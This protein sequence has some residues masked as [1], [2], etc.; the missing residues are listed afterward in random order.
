MIPLPDVSSLLLAVFGM[1]GLAVIAIGIAR[2]SRDARDPSARLLDL[3]IVGGGVGAVVWTAALLVARQA[4]PLV[5]AARREVSTSRS[6]WSGR[7]WRASSPARR[8]RCPAGWRS[9]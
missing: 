3:F 4:S 2:W 5:E 1:A 6:S 8:I 9:R 7:P